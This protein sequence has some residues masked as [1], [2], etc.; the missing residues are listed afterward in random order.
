MEHIKPVFPEPA[1]LAKATG[2]KYETCYGWFR[3]GGIPP[4]YNGAVMRA[5]AAAGSP[6][7]L[8]QLE[9]AYAAHLVRRK[10]ARLARRAAT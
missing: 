3:H 7:T 10:E 4:A 5:M 6:I 1:P 8:E 2:V 9:Q